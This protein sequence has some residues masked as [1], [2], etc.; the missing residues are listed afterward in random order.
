MKIYT[1]IGTRDIPTDSKEIIDKILNLYEVGLKNYILRSG[2]APGMDSL[3]EMC[4]YKYHKDT[5]QEIFLPWKNFNNSKS[6]LF[7]I[8]EEAKILAKEYH[9]AP[10]RL[11]DAA[12]KLMSRNGYQVLGYDL[13]TPTDLVVCWVKDINKGGTSQ[14]IRIARDN[15]IPI[16][17][18][19]NGY[20]YQHLVK[21]LQDETKEIN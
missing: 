2:S 4:H 9:P 12:L 11:T 15:N 13:K 19:Y 5:N 8:T 21:S 7:N 16:F 1:G 17:N 14:A 20:E 18:I 3:F 6:Q 10:S